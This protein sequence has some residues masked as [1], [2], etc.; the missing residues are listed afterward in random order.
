M[1]AM[2]L[3]PDQRGNQSG[4]QQPRQDLPERHRVAFDERQRL[5]R[6]AFDRRP[7]FECAKQFDHIAIAFSRIDRSLE[8]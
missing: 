6:N 8:R 4:E 2:A 5:R 3:P 7:A 1:P